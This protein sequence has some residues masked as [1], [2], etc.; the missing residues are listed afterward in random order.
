MLKRIFFFTLILV[1]MVGCIKN[2]P[3]A[4]RL[5]LNGI[6]GLA[7]YYFSRNSGEVISVIKQ[8]YTKHPTEYSLSINKDTLRLGDEFTA[9]FGVFNPSYRVII[10]SPEKDTIVGSYDFKNPQAKGFK[11]TP[12][13]EGL[14]T[15]EGRLEYD[16]LV[17]PFEYKFIVLPK[18]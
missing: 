2:P 14:F 12:D 7:H 5:E 8:D 1:V 13:K 10:I 3:P 15:L 6:N 4:K 11:Y 9:D 17:V 16:T 18:D